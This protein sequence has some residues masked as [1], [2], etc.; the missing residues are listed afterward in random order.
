MFLVPAK[1]AARQASIAGQDMDSLIPGL[2]FLKG[3]G[4]LRYPGARHRDCNNRPEPIVPGAAGS[5]AQTPFDFGAVFWCTITSY[6]YP[7]VFHSQLF[8]VRKTGILELPATECIPLR[9]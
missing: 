4:H 8:V 2:R 7:I 3:R 1:I 6:F 5:F 9:I